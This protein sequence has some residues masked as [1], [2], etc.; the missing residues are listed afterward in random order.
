MKDK[1]LDMKIDEYQPLR[2]IVFQTLRKAIITGEL[3]PGER[4]METKLAEK[5]GVSRTP[6]REAIRKLEL[7]GLV[8]MVPRKGAQV[9]PFTQKDIKDVLEVRGALEALAARLACERMDERAFLRLEL[10]NTEYEYAA[11]EG[12]IETMI[13]KDVEFHEVIFEATEN[14]KLVQMF[15]NLGEQVHRFRIAYLK[16]SEASVVVQEEHRQILKALRERDVEL[17]SELSTVHI[18]RQSDTIIE[19]IQSQEESTN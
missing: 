17:V 13:A 11:Q 8:I 12:D 15:G 14:D 16:N 1:K 6:V 9:A 7:E 5:L 18:Q 19:F 2:D 10:V 3:L 4:L